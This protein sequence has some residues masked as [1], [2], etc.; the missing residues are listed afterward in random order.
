MY[1]DI[2]VTIPTIYVGLPNNKLV[3]FLK[4]EVESFRSR[5]PTFHCLLNPQLK[6]RHWE[7]IEQCI[8]QHITWD[9]GSVTLVA[10]QEMSVCRIAVL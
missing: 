9:H 3:S 10:L 2:V 7:T 5:L 4:E 6:L 8:G 1:I